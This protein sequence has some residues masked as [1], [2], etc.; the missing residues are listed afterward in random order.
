MQSWHSFGLHFGIYLRSLPPA[1]N[2]K[3]ILMMGLV[4]VTI[5]ASC[6]ASDPSTDRLDNTR[7][8]LRAPGNHVHTPMGHKFQL[9]NLYLKI[10]TNRARAR[11]L[12][13]TESCSTPSDNCWKNGRAG[14]CCDSGKTCF[15]KTAYYAQCKPACP[16]KVI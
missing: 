9:T 11:S 14:A 13:A 16:S 15:R 5:F 6:C 10:Q 3:M 8:S 4:S 2:R 1:N 12:V 7:F